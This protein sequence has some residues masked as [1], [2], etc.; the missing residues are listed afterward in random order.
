MNKPIQY[1]GFLA[2]LGAVVYALSIWSP[3]DK[4]KVGPFELGFYRQSDLLGKWFHVESTVVDSSQWLATD[5]VW[6]PEDSTFF[7]EV[8]EVVYVPDSQIQLSDVLSFESFF[9]ELD[10]LKARKRQKLRILHYG[11]SQLE[12]DRIT[13]VFRDALQ[14]RYGG[15]GFGY[16]AMK[17]LVSPACIDFQD[18]TGWIRKT[19]FGRR[20]TSIHDG[21][22]GHLASFTAL[23]PNDSGVYVGR[24]TLVER[25]W[26]YSRARNFSTLN[27]YGES[28]HPVVVQVEVADSVFST[29]ELPSGEWTRTIPHPDTTVFDLVV[30]G[31]STT[32]IY[33]LSFES[34]TGV[35][36]DNVA[37]RGASGL[38][39][40]K[41]DQDQLGRKLREEDYR[42][43]IL[44]YG[45]NTVPYLKDAAH[46][47]RV[48]RSLGRQMDRLM[49]LAPNAKI[50]FI[51][52]S[53]M[54]KKEGLE[55]VSYPLI[56]PLKKAIRHEVLKRGQAYWDLQDVMGGPGSMVHWVEQEP[57]L[58]VVDYIHFTPR[59]A[60]WVGER[61]IEE[62]DVLQSK[63][64]SKRTAERMAEEERLRKVAD[65][66]A[67]Q[68]SKLDT[69]EPLQT[70]NQ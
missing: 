38:M 47:L 7:N 51:G 3:E 69:L 35:Q 19:V 41:M 45:G 8:S 9:E 55:M 46:C 56:I 37:M 4:I 17:P 18:G 6:T 48:A 33:G 1:F 53:D 59:G 13:S 49:S 16:V 31:D 50:L 10:A 44:Q 58:A 20:D 54:A 26:G 67:A 22:Y 23:T 27:I 39:F 63:V 64:Q 36:V 12:G 60:K 70:Q 14:R 30:V 15:T 2:L 32:R 24:T 11:D 21:K 42:L 68:Q 52:P 61:L 62:L 29:T 5:S 43:I 25:N 34:L 40:T 28:V 66:I 57:A 65:S